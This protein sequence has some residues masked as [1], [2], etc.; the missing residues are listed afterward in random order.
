M[1][2]KV[3]RAKSFSTFLA[4]AAR[5]TRARSFR[6][7]KRAVIAHDHRNVRRRS[8]T[9]HRTFPKYTRPF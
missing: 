1:T 2:S 7:V 4:F 3:C 6:P 8:H 9:V 5:M